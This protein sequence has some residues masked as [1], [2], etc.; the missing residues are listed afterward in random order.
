VTTGAGPTSLASGNP[1]C[2]AQHGPHTTARNTVARGRPTRT[3]HVTHNKPPGLSDPTDDATLS[4]AR[5]GVASSSAGP[6]IPAAAAGMSPNAP[7]GHAHGA[8]AK[9]GGVSGA[10][11]PARV[12]SGNTGPRRGSPGMVTPACLGARNPLDGRG[13]QAVADENRGAGVV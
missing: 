1:P 3:K 8:A 2:A 6:D 13:L 10:C 9:K 4:P 12:S 7:G 11:A 5:S